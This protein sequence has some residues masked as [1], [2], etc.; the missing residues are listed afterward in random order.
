MK[1]IVIKGKSRST[2]K[3]KATNS[4]ESFRKIKKT[5]TAKKNYKNNFI[6]SYIKSCIKTIKISL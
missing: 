1:K 3:K 6:K 4:Y 5:K 2:C